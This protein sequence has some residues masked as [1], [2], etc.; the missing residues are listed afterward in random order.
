MNVVVPK[1]IL[2]AMMPMHV[3]VSPAGRMECVGPVLEKVTAGQA[4]VGR[5]FFDVFSVMRPFG[6][7]SFVE[8]YRNDHTRLRVRVRFGARKDDHMTLR[9]SASRLPEKGGMLINMSLGISVVEAVHKFD[10]SAE[11]FAPADPTIDMLYL[12]EVNNAAFGESKRLNQRLQGAKQAAELQAQTDTLTDL[13]NRRALDKRLRLLTQ[14]GTPFALMTVDLDYFKDVNDSYG[15]AAGDV[16]LQAVANVLRTETRAADYI[17]R[18]GGD[19]FV[20]AFEDL[21][22]EVQLTLIAKRII[23]GFEQPVNVGR[24]ECHVSASIGITLSTFYEE[25]SADKMMVDADRALYASKHRGR[26]RATMFD[27]V[28]RLVEMPEE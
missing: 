23:A 17:A 5:P 24:G 7:K 25:P 9:G 12:I 11:D 13:A 16:V 2:D 26:S 14:Q 4:V 3:V 1:T 22:D 20:I 21:T 15:H 27:P 10:L 8:L 19:E 28:N 6:A 18:V